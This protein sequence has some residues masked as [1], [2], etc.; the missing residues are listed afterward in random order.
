MGDKQ[1]HPPHGIGAHQSQPSGDGVGGQVTG[2]VDAQPQPGQS[3]ETQN[4]Q[5]MKDSLQKGL[6][7]EL[8]RIE[9]LESQL[10]GSVGAHREAIEQAIRS[11]RE[12]ADLLRRQ[13]RERGWKLSENSPVRVANK[14]VK[15]IVAALAG[16]AVVVTGAF[17]GS[18]VT[19]GPDGLIADAAPAF[20][21]AVEP[22][23]LETDDSAVRRQTTNGSTPA[24]GSP[25]VVVAE[26]PVEQ[27][28]EP[29]TQS[30]TEVADEEPTHDEASQT[31]ETS[32][33]VY[34]DEP[35]DGEP[36]YEEPSEDVEDENE[37]YDE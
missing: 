27:A 6:D 19:N 35:E 4:A 28:R 23:S 32:H 22:I 8:E 14:A 24:N 36:E 21:T 34:D 10:P 5:A 11:H 3:W 20:G 7:G 37:G 2:V 9:Q 30:T 17:F 1:I 12:F 26:L 18:R 29:Q 16:A 15:A 31:N 13:A 25:T 33:A